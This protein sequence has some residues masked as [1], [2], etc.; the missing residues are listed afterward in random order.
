[1]LC[2]KGNML[3][4]KTLNDLR[5]HNYPLLEPLYDYCYGILQGAVDGDSDGADTDFIKVE[6]WQGGNIY[7]VQTL[8][9]L[10]SIF[11]TEV[12]DANTYKSLLETAASFDSCQ[13]VVGGTFAEV[14]L[15]TNNAGGNVYYIPRE[16][17]DQC[18][19]VALSVKL[20]EV[21]NN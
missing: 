11:T 16:I 13:Y 6:E 8:E 18:E 21:S 10:G 7:V 9:D 5:S 15:A 20:T 14:F 12:K 19:N 2:L 4:F 1:M 17:A 3:E